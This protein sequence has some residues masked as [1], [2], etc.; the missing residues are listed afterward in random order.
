MT[1]AADPTVDFGDDFPCCRPQDAGELFDRFT[2]DERWLGYGYLGERRHALD[3]TD[4]EAPA[5]PDLV[6]EADRRVVQWAGIHRW[7]GEELFAWA[8]S[9]L[10]RWYG[11]AMFGGTGSPD[12]RFERAVRCGTLARVR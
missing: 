11:D 10:G 9:K 8:N 4:P 1:A 3:S 2:D 5:Q 7:T 12:E 6:A